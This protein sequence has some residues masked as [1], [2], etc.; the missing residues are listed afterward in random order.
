MTGRKPHARRAEPRWKEG[1]SLART[2][3]ERLAVAYRRATAALA[4]C[5]RTKRPDPMAQARDTAAAERLA[6]DAAGYLMRLSE[7]AESGD[8]S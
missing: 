6:D 7:R 2:A 1:M 3:D 5:R 8:L 4:H